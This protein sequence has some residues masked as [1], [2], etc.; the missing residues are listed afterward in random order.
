MLMNATRSGSRQVRGAVFL[1]G[2]LCAA[3]SRQAAGVQ[4]VR[5]YD[6]NVISVNVV[7][8]TATGSSMTAAQFAT[9]VGLAYDNDRGGVIDGSA[10]GGQTNIVDFGATGTR[11]LT[12]EV[13][14]NWA[15]GLSNDTGTAISTIGS[16]S[17]VI[18]DSTRPRVV[19]EFPNAV[20]GGGFQ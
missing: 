20:Q 16:W 15:I 3:I 2:A 9:T 6:E 13:P 18:A 11:S 5:T 8:F 7:D 14:T 19:F 1:A 17:T 4:A 10:V 12:Y